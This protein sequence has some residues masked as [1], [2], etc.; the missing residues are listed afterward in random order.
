MKWITIKVKKINLKK[1]K[2]NVRDKTKRKDFRS[3]FG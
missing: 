3:F 1:D 2:Y